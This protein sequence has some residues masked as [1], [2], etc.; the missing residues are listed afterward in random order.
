MATVPAPILDARDGDELTAEAIG[1]LPAELSDR[2][3]A[4]PAVVLLEAAGAFYD[5]LLYVINR[6]PSAVIQKA[7]ALVGV[8]VAAAQPS[9]V[10]LTFTLSAPQPRDTIIPADT[11]VATSDGSVVF[12]TLE[13]LTIA[14]YDDTL[15]GTITITSGSATI[16]G[17]GTSFTSDWVGQQ[18]QVRGAAEWYTVTAVGGT[19]SLTVS[20]TATASASGA[21]RVG[22]NVGSTNSQSTTSG[23]ATKVAADALTVLQSAPANVASVTNAAAA[24]NGADEQTTDQAIAEAQTSFAARDMACSADDYAYFAVKTLGQGGRAKALKTMNDTTAEAGYTT[25]AVLS[26]SWTLAS[27]ATAQERANVMRDL[28]G[29]TVSGVSVVD[30][31]AN[32]SDRSATG[33]IPVIAVVRKTAYDTVTTQTAVAEKINTLLSPN[34]YDWGRTLYIDDLSEAGGGADAVDRVL[35]INGR[36]ACGFDYTA[37]VGTVAFANGSTTATFSSTASVDVVA[38]GATLGQRFIID[39]T[40]SKVYLVVAKL[41]STT[42]QID[43]AFENASYTTASGAC[44]YFTSADEALTNWYTLPYANLSTSSSSPP[45]SIIVVGVAS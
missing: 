20:T 45:A 22:P 25:V 32:I 18:I 3:D 16:T 8:Q 6:W 23:L 40:N 38:T 41:S 43:R 33:K 2:S 1:S 21:F 13:D 44:F 29:R 24:A 14:A 35:T 4:N 42:V 39:A 28:A 26:P 37:L 9:T 7:L 30:V 15:A 10:T 19:T 5:R 34:T 12:A 11:Q 27:P 36:I 17:S 31:V